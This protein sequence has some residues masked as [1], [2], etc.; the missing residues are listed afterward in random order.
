MVTVSFTYLFKN[1]IVRVC[2]KFITYNC[3]VAQYEIIII[4]NLKVIF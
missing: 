2:Y 3:P 1:S 4:L